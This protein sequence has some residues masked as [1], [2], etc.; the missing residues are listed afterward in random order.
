MDSIAHR[1]RRVRRFGDRLSKASRDG[2][3]ALE[4]NGRTAGFLEQPCFWCVANP[5]DPPWNVGARAHPAGDRPT[6]S[7][8]RQVRRRVRSHHWL[9][10][11]VSAW[12]AHSS[13]SSGA[14]SS[15]SDA[16]CG[17]IRGWNSVDRYWE[18]ASARTSELVC[19][20]PNAV[21]ALE[22][23]RVG[24]NAPLWWT[25][26]CRWRVSHCRCG[27][28]LGPVGARRSHYRN[29]RRYGSSADLFVSRME[30]GA[31]SGERRQLVLTRIDQ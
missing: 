5:R 25:P 13:P 3:N 23:P 26:F 29:P 14:G 19:G 11:A 8:L 9:A 17:S 27:V 22:R 2:P 16:A 18:S 10:D 4:R 12:H 1:R 6:G 28:A 20:D 31:G 7:E 21:D 30:T 15:R 24:E